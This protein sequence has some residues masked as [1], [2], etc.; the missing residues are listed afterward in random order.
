MSNPNP[1]HVVTGKVRFSY[2]H[3]FQPYSQNQGQEP[4]YSTTILVPKTDAQTKALIDAAVQAAIQA[5]ANKFGAQWPPQPN[6]CIH[7]GDGVR[8]NTGAPFSEECKGHWVFT[9]K[10]KDQPKVVDAS[11][12]PI[13]NPGDF[14]SGCYGRVSV[15]FYPYN[16]NGRKGIGCGLQN[17]QK[18]EDGQPLGN[19]TTAEDDFGETAPVV[20]QPQMA[21]NPYA[22]PAAQ[23]NPYAVP[24]Q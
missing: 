2:A 13:I 17:V 6:I 24:G 5:G 19:R 11:M 9:A 10:S 4:K 20:G 12:Q 14:Y 21:P 16:S 23:P 22:V 8:P 18:L 1:T 3:V 7:D 15:D